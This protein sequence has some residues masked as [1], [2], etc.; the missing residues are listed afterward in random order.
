MKR[1]Q[2]RLAMTCAKR[3]FCGAVT[4]AASRSRESSARSA[5]EAAPLSSQNCANDQAGATVVP[6]E[7]V[8]GQFAGERPRAFREHNR[9]GGRNPGDS[10]DHAAGE[11]PD[12]LRRDG[13]GFGRQNQQRIFPRVPF[14]ELS[15]QISL[16]WLRRKA[17]DVDD[18][19]AAVDP[20]TEHEIIEAL[21]SA[22]IP[23]R[24]GADFL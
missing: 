16:P 10:A 1:C 2:M 12:R 14:G 6:A 7:G 5:R 24:E 17:G 4:S 20:G 13:I 9:L 22:V 15:E 11:M 8:S 19:T 23:N 21:E 3:S 18:P